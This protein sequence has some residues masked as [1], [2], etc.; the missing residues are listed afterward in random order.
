MSKSVGNVIDPSSIVEKHGADVLRLWVALA[1]TTSDIAYSERILDKTLSAYKKIRSVLR[2]LNANLFDF[3][4]DFS[5]TSF[6][7]KPIDLHMALK[8]AEVVEKCDKSM[9]DFSFHVVAHDLLH[10]VSE[11]V[12]AFYLGS[13]KDRLYCEAATSES[14]KSA[15]ACIAL[16]LN[17]LCKPLEVFVPH[18]IHELKSYSAFE[19][20]CSSKL[21]CVETAVSEYP[22]KEKVASLFHHLGKIGDSINSSVENSKELARSDIEFCILQNSDFGSLLSE[23]G[24]SESD[25]V[26]VFRCRSVTLK[27]M[28]DCTKFREYSF[29]GSE[30]PISDDVRMCIARNEDAQLCPRCR[31]YTSAAIDVLCTRCDQVIYP[32]K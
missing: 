23:V 29:C 30:V 13:I 10:F 4:P 24:L 22:K 5:T 28:Q 15:Q 32:Y 31:L 21:A 17:A 18:L 11:D 25:M 7:I 19:E 1:D 9:E 16:M 12:S 14:R 20:T 8:C 27:F 6:S 3:A 2:I 26:E